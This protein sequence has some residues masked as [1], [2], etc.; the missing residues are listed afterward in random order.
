MLILG[1]ILILMN[2]VCSKKFTT[3]YN[4]RHRY[5]VPET[6]DLKHRICVTWLI[7]FVVQELLGS[8]L[9][10]YFRVFMV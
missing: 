2:L 3:N 5:K 7:P 6:I 10:K 4:D 9:S 1:D 8:H